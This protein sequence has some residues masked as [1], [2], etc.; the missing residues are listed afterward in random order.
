MS[1]TPRSALIRK[2]HSLPKGDAERRKILAS[3]GDTW[4]KRLNELKY[5]FMQEVCVRAVGILGDEG[6]RAKFD[7]RGVVGEVKGEVNGEKVTIRY[8]WDDGFSTIKST[9]T[10]GRDSRTHTNKVLSLSPDNVAS[11]SIFTSFGGLLD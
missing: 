6:I 3:F 7:V 4:S 10:W 5:D 1:R 2:A 8:Q 9:M 11:E